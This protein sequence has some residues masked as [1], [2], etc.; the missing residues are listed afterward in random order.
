MY[1]IKLLFSFI[2]AQG[3]LTLK[4]APYLGIRQILYRTF[5]IVIDFYT[6]KGTVQDSSKIKN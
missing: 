4:A 6:E 2:S 1:G 3:N 5:I